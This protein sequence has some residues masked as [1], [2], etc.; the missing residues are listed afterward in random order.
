MARGAGNFQGV[1][2]VSRSSVNTYAAFNDAQ[3]RFFDLY[4]QGDIYGIK[5]FVYWDGKQP[6]TE[7]DKIA[8]E[9]NL[10]AESFACWPLEPE[11]RSAVETMTHE[12]CKQRSN[13]ILDYLK[14][15]Q[16][17]NNKTLALLELTAAADFKTFLSGSDEKLPFAVAYFQSLSHKILQKMEEK[18]QTEEWAIHE[19]ANTKPRIEGDIELFNVEDELALEPEWTTSSQEIK[20]MINWLL[21]DTVPLLYKTEN[22]ELDAKARN[23]VEDFTG[24]TPNAPMLLV[25]EPALGLLNSGQYQ[26]IQ[27]N[28]SDHTGWAFA[29][30]RDS[31]RIMLETMIHELFHSVR[32]YGW[33]SSRGLSPAEK[34]IDEGLVS[35]VSMRLTKEGDKTRELTLDDDYLPYIISM[36]HMTKGLSDQDLKDL[37]IAPYNK[38]EEEFAFKITGSRDVSDKT[39]VI[40]ILEKALGHYQ[41][42]QNSY[43]NG[44]NPFDHMEKADQLITP[45][46]LAKL[47]AK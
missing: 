25:E 34:A 17:I 6:H 16:I 32:D 8:F 12:Y 18:P 13:E 4:H 33:P 5:N 47:K 11:A 7:D 31:K 45:E 42:G 21:N 36:S 40:E 43:R 19:F 46:A 9:L 26:T 24:I 39:K 28:H 44:E 37:L 30:I 3:R 15:N 23:L 35:L 38:L 2:T 14:A 41:E 1:G 27:N 20:M 29:K 22:K 10:L